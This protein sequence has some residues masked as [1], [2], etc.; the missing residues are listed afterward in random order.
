MRARYCAYA[1]NIPDFIIK[2]THPGN[3]DYDPDLSAWK[4][5]ISAFATTTTFKSLEIEK[6]IENPHLAIVAFSA[7]LMQ[8]GKPS[9]FKEESLFEKYHGRWLY[10]GVRLVE[11]L[12]PNPL[13]SGEL[14]LLPLAYLGDSVLREKAQPISHITPEM[15]TLVE[16][17]IETMDACDGLG[18]AAP[19][20]HRSIQLFVIR[21]PIV[22]PRGDIELGAV[23]VFINPHISSYGDTFWQAQEGCLSIPGVRAQVKRAKEIMITYQ[24]LQGESFSEKISGWEARVIQHEYDHLQGVL[25][26]DHLAEKERKKLDPKL[27]LLKQRFHDHKDL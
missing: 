26:Y 4:E 18:L 1:K 17:M 20:V 9:S 11:S 5:S 16:H 15:H 8:N 23:K 24:D 10:K 3:P 14:R 22:N 27:D 13:T 21:K 6:V 7:Q 2:T 12:S 19:Q 25:F